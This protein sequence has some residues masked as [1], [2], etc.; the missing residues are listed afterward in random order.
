MNEQQTAW[1]RFASGRWTRTLPLRPGVYPVRA[2]HLDKAPRYFPV[3]RMS[4]DVVSSM[5]EY[6]TWPDGSPLRPKGI[7]D[8]LW[9]WSEPLPSLPDPPKETS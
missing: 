3:I 8:T 1:L 4:H 5:N 6:Y 2:I 7:I 9:I